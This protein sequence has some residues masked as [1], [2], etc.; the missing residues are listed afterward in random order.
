[1]TPGTTPASR[2]CTVEKRTGEAARAEYAT[3]KWV[4]SQTDALVKAMGTYLQKYVKRKDVDHLIAEVE[5]GKRATDAVG[6]QVDKILTELAELKREE[7]RW[8]NG[9]KRR[10]TSGA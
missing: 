8:Q 9:S 5:Q 10:A 6:R 2:R 1:M 4:N 7:P 3:R